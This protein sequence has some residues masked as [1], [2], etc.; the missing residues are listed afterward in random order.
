VQVEFKMDK[1]KKMVMVDEERDSFSY[2]VIEKYAASCFGLT[3]WAEVLNEFKEMHHPEHG[4]KL[5][6]AL[7][8]ETKS[9]LRLNRP[10]HDIEVHNLENTEEHY[11]YES[12]LRAK[13]E[14]LYQVQSESSCPELYI[15][16]EEVHLKTR[17]EVFGEFDEKRLF[18][19]NGSLAKLKLPGE[20]FE[21]GNGVSP[22]VE[23]QLCY[24]HEACG[25]K[26]THPGPENPHYGHDIFMRHGKGVWRLIQVGAG[27]KDWDNDTKH[28]Q[29]VP[30][31][32][33]L[34]YGVRLV[35]Y[36][37]LPKELMET[38]P[39]KDGFNITKDSYKQYKTKF[40]RVI[41][42][43]TDKYATRDPN[44]KRKPTEADNLAAANLGKKSNLIQDGKKRARVA[45][46]MVRSP[47]DIGENVRPEHDVSSTSNK[48]SKKKHV[49]SLPK[50]IKA[51]LLHNRALELAKIIVPTEGE[52]RNLLLKELWQVQQFAEEMDDSIPWPKEITKL[53]GR[54]LAAYKEKVSDH[55]FVSDDLGP[56]WEKVDNMVDH[57]VWA[58]IGTSLNSIDSYWWAAKVIG[59]SGVEKDTKPSC[60]KVSFFGDLSCSY[61]SAT[62]KY[63]LPFT[64]TIRQDCKHRLPKNMQEQWNLGTNTAILEHQ[65]PQPGIIAHVR[66]IDVDGGEDS[67]YRGTVLR[68]EKRL[69][70]GQLLFVQYDDGAEE[71]VEY[72][73]PDVIIENAMAAKPKPPKK[74]REEKERHR[75]ALDV[76]Y[77]G[78]PRGGEGVM[79]EFLARYGLDAHADILFAAGAIE[80]EALLEDFGKV[81]DPKHETEGGGFHQ[82]LVQMGLAQHASRKVHSALRIENQTRLRKAMAGLAAGA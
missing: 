42:N 2:S 44:K 66:F 43:Y 74:P 50:R 73:N 67:W 75:P 45:N 61:L 79:R 36:C 77:S 59:R 17:Q 58:R 54:D 7:S 41:K 38:R 16:G 53:V 72:P 18:P 49:T 19:E 55:E 81:Y 31:R 40:K 76:M 13:M 57:L 48:G 63:I 9:I 82:N 46:T 69:E 37:T 29:H 33:R 15:D 21:D 3:S 14:L 80:L 71:E 34:G 5:M 26:V 39:T 4:T 23:Y 12:S 62:S 64:P 60:R 65:G 10:A 30:R 70:G 25:M 22:E 6:V 51:T 35:S 20:L 11:A 32:E 47:G 28:D 1:K 68:V 24:I 56:G 52:D 27:C 78:I 8:A